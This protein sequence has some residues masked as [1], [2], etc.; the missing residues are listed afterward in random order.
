MSSLLSRAGFNLPAIDLD[1]MTISYPSIFE[2]MDDLR[3]MGESNAVTLRR[4]TMKRDTLLA[5]DAIYRGRLDLRWRSTNYTLAK[6]HGL[7]LHGNKDGT[8]P[9]TFQIIF[10]VS[11]CGIRQL[12]SDLIRFNDRSGGSQVLHSQRYV[13][14]SYDQ[15]YS[16][17]TTFGSHWHADQPSSL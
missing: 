2:L 16:T 8:I 7:A 6:T 15:Y 10:C 9:A 5:A 14:K 4:P 1:E 17:L 3:Y 13:H 12:L 11:L